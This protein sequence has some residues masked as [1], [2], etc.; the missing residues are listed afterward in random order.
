MHFMQH[1]KDVLWVKANIENF[2]TE[3]IRTA[4][5]DLAWY[6]NL[7]LSMTGES[8]G[9]INRFG[10]LEQAVRATDAEL[11]ARMK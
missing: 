2:S 4:A 9:M 10:R 5:P 3:W 8:N 1:T 11:A 7:A 6:G